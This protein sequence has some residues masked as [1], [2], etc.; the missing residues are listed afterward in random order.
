MLT[1]TLLGESR[2]AVCLLHH[3]FRI[4]PAK[5]GVCTAT[6]SLCMP[7]VEMLNKSVDSTHVIGCLCCHAYSC[8]LQ[9]LTAAL[10]HKGVYLLRAQCVETAYLVANLPVKP[11]HNYACL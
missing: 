4:I 11:N 10:S 3:S 5:T 1:Y 6:S 8:K 9:L 7:D 2:K